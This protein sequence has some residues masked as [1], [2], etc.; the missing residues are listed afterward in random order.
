MDACINL[1]RSLKI[2]KT[3]NDIS[4]ALIN[5]INQK[6]L[7]KF[8]SQF[9]KKGDL[10]FD[11]G[12]NLGSRTEAFLKLGAR[13][14]AVEPQ[15]SCIEKLKKKYGNN[16]E[17]TLIK[18]AVGDSLGMGELMISD[19]HTVSTM[20]KKWID[21]LKSSNM[22]FVPTEAF[23]WQTSK[24]IEVTTL[25]KLIK[26]FG[27]PAFCKIDVEGYEY[28]VLRGLTQPI[29]VISFEFMPT[30]EFILSAIDT[31]KHLASIG[32]VEFNYAVGESTK[33]VLKKWVGSDEIS[34]ILSDLPKKIS[35]FG[36]IYA[37]FIS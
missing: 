23:E 35:V 15:D 4:L 1:M 17:V 25:D 33:L 5:T 12:A 29:E 10:C 7:L 19:T 16:K 22:F 28:E 14:V 20:S 32:K 30:Q 9:I 18:E 11:I 3:V 26:E 36:D 8:Y 24:K 6:R 13:V 27:R 2:Y 31:V 37:R 34:S 21:S